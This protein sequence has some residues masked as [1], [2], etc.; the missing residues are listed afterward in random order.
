MSSETPVH[1]PLAESLGAPLDRVRAKIS[2][3][4]HAWLR[5]FIALSPYVVMASADGTGHC[6]ASPRGGVPGFVRVLDERTLFVP[7]ESGNRLLQTLHNLRENP[8]IGLLFLIP[9]MRETARVNGHAEPLSPEDSRWGGLPLEGGERARYRWGTLVHV[10]E[11]Y[12][13]CGR[14]SKFSNLWNT[15]DIER[16][17]A[18]PPLP[19]RPP[20]TPTR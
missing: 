8:G 14:A 17:L 12:Y 9:G 19:K 2:P 18:N 6:D 7:E 1:D 20:G 16:N 15:A 10:S 13:H 4:L 5:E 11:A 3:V